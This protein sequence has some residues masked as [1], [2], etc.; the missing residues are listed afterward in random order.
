MQVC[1]VARALTRNP[2]SYPGPACG[3]PKVD[4]ALPS[5]AGAVRPL[6]AGIQPAATAA[7]TTSVGH[8]GEERRWRWQVWWRWQG[9]GQAG[10]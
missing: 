3:P 1:C 9:L 10:E 8:S 2:A 6:V 4:P 7:T 5:L